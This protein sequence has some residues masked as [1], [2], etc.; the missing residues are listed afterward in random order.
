MGNSLSSGGKDQ[1]VERIYVGDSVGGSTIAEPCKHNIQCSR[2]LLCKNPNSPSSGRCT[3]TC[4]MQAPDNE[5]KKIE[6]IKGDDSYDEAKIQ[7]NNS[8][9]M[10]DDGLA[11]TCYWKHDEYGTEGCE[12][13][14]LDKGIVK[15]PGLLCNETGLKGTYH[16]MTYL[17]CGSCPF[18]KETC[19]DTCTRHWVQNSCWVSDYDYVTCL[20]PAGTQCKKT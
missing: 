3:N 11:R 9:F 18:P 10:L 20:C 16:D 4:S 19:P 6:K 7:C 12:E 5:C 14:G 2:G 13:F 1:A 17:R 8:W 15:G